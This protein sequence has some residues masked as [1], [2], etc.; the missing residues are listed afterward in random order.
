MKKHNKNTSKRVSRPD[1]STNVNVEQSIT[2]R[3]IWS[4]EFFISPFSKLL[5]FNSKQMKIN[6]TIKNNKKYDNTLYHNI[7]FS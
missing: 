6:Y 5:K 1:I 3:W 2:I 4:E 7:A